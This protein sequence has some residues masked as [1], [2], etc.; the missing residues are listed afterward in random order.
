MTHF[1][2]LLHPSANRV[3]AESS[4]ALSEAELEIFGD[5]AVAGG[6]G[7][8]RPEVIGG[9][10]YL[11]FAADELDPAA[12]ALISNV[13]TA[14]ALFALEGELLRPLE[15]TP[16]AA[17]DDDLLTVQKYVGKTNETFTR[18]LLNVTVLASA[19]TLGD[20]LR[21]LDP[22]CG[23]GTTLNQALMY[24][25]DAAGI[26]LDPKDFDAYAGFLS[27]W[28]KR[29]R[30]KHRHE[31]HPVR[32]ERQLVARRLDVELAATREQFKS[33]ETQSLTVFQADTV[34]A[35]EFFKPR[36]FDAIV[37]DA[38]YG[39]QHGSRSDDS[40]RR[41]PLELIRAAAPGWAT[42]LRPGGAIG[43]SWNTHV[44][45]RSALGEALA[46]V[47]LEPVETPA[48]QRFGHRVDQAIM[49]D[50]IV[51]TKSLSS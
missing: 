6:I 9:A 35:G 26:D 25:Y 44:A 5:R 34:R 48:Y 29:K 1:A 28:L 15:L 17:Y 19:S 22:M 2:L 27:A 47:G 21:I 41:G 38:P 31:M 32:R 7:E 12:L 13:S 23:R 3:Y 18:L 24:G 46:E 4:I 33:G 14:Y 49:R 36:T 20:R 16:L 40:L 8:L 42:L 50:L 39:V 30:L 37:T 10:T 11:T 43:I 45:S 51:A